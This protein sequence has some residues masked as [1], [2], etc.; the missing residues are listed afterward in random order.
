VIG[1]RS[2][3][4]PR[5][6]IISSPPTPINELDLLSIFKLEPKPNNDDGQGMNAWTLFARKRL[7]RSLPVSRFT[8]VG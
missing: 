7:P 4:L 5:C 3:L 1:G 6:D 2:I 8:T